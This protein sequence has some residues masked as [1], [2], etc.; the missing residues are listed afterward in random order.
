MARGLKHLS[1]DSVGMLRSKEPS[2]TWSPEGTSISRRLPPF[3]EGTAS[4]QSPTRRRSAAWDYHL[5]LTGY[6]GSEWSSSRPKSVECTCCLRLF[7]LLLRCCCGLISDSQNSRA[8]L[9]LCFLLCSGCWFLGLLR[10][11]GADL[12]DLRRGGGQDS[13]RQVWRD[14]GESFVSLGRS[15]WRQEDHQTPHQDA[16]ESRSWQRT[17]HHEQ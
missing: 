5:G 11:Q 12:A 3:I 7:L 1:T 17:G 9:R 2:R 14:L 6:A 8:H 4:H 16:S 13:C 15:F 10:N